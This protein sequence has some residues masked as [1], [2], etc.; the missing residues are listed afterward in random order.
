VNK[1]KNKMARRKRTALR[2]PGALAFPEIWFA[3]LS[4]THTTVTGGCYLSNHLLQEEQF[5][6]WCQFLWKRNWIAWREAI[7]TG[8]RRIV[9]YNPQQLPLMLE[10]NWG[11][12]IKALTYKK[13]RGPL[14]KEMVRK[15]RFNI[16]SYQ[17]YKI[18]SLI[19]NNF[20]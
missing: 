19:S 18:S 16:L 8:R 9:N 17:R 2:G 14:L 1:T 15:F 11:R 12:W 6:D 10:W 3:S 4:K 5:R 7:Q 20:I 13:K